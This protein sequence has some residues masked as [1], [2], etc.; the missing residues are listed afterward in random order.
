MF[1]PVG[2]RAVSSYRQVG[3]SSVVTDASPHTLIS[4]LFDGLIQELNG[5]RGAISRGSVD[6][7]G[8]HILK[9]VRILDEGLRGGVNLQ[10][11]GELAAN[12][13]A[14]YAYCSQ[15]LTIANLKNDLSL[16]DEVLGLISPVAESWRAIR[17][18]AS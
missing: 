17:P 3:A 11:G 2:L 4:L 5:A 6:E 18:V 1:T 13:N 15:R 12:L 9:A 7:K 16:V 14:L 10:S 8:R